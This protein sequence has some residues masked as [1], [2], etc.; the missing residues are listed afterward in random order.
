M[1]DEFD[2]RPDLKFLEHFPQMVI[3]SAS[4]DKKAR[5]YFS[6]GEPVG[7]QISDVP[8]LRSQFFAAVV[9]L[10]GGFVGPGCSELQ[11]CSFRKDLGSHGLEY[12]PGFSMLRA[13][14]VVSSLAP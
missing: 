5:P 6:V 3:N 8:L 4:A 7:R 11:T 13:S 9:L 10:A 2:A 1:C 14:I 12:F